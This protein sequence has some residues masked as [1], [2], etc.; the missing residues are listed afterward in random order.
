MERNVV[1]EEIESRLTLERMTAPQRKETYFP[2]LQG[3]DREDADDWLLD[4]L[5]LVIQIQRRRRE[6]QETRTSDR[7]A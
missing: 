3:Q 6:E 5:R 1:Y 7:G 2:E 4:Y